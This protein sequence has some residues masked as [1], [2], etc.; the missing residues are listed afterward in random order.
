M[1]SFELTAYIE[2]LFPNKILSGHEFGETLF[3]SLFPHGWGKN[4]PIFTIH[5]AHLT[6]GRLDIAN[7][8][9]IILGL[10]IKYLSFLN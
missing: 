2:I 1:T 9:L 7:A 6:P 4:L 10:P 5:F 3:N 8:C